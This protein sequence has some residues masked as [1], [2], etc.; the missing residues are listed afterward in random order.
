MASSKR[1]RR[2]FH[3][4]NKE[5]RKAFLEYVEKRFGIPSSLFEGRHIYLGSSGKIIMGPALHFEP[6]SAG[7]TVG[8]LSKSGNIKP[9]TN[10]IQTF[11]RFATK[12]VVSLSK[13]Q[14]IEFLRGLDVKA[15]CDC[16]EGYVVVS[17]IYPLGCGLLQRGIVKNMLPKAKHQKIVYL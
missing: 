5:I 11:G 9:T 14:A 16:E 17:Y 7:I 4:E 13:S 2:I 1:Q 10:F 6:L 8:R 15:D 12:N 3:S